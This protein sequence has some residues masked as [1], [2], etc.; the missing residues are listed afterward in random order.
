MSDASIAIIGGTG[1]D[2][3]AGLAL[4]DSRRISTPFGEPASPLALG[5]FA[6]RPVCFLP[7]HGSSHALAP[8][9]INYRANIW[10]LRCAGVRSVI[11]CAAVG[12]IAPALGPGTIVVPDNLIDYT[13]GRESTFHEPPD[14]AHV[15]FTNPYS[16]RLRDALLAGGADAG[17]PIVA[18]GVYG[19]TQGPRLET[20]AE[21]D[22][23]DRDGCT[24]VGMTG[25]PEAVLAREAGLQYATC[26]LV[27]N[28]AA[29]R[30]EGE[31]TMEDIR[32]ALESGMTQV[33]TV[34][35][36]ALKRLTVPE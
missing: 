18:G 4:T 7:R 28:A 3:L 21:I 23:M 32:A 14:V 19:A 1:L 30:A 36:H 10:A 31:I 9:R 15:D 26:A 11:A 33:R 24:I 17:I 2:A 16:A 35:G 27:V 13:W 8:H 12:G 20:A 25:M 6:G 5:T 29:G 34:L 22:R